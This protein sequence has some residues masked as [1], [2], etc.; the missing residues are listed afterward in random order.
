MKKIASIL[1]VIIMIFT[2][3][4][5]SLSRKQQG[6]DSNVNQNPQVVDQEYKNEIQEPETITL[7]PE[8]INDYLTFILNAKDIELYD[9][10]YDSSTNTGHGKLSVKIQPKKRGTFDGVVLNVTLVTD[11][12]GWVAPDSW[13]ERK[14]E[15]VVSLDGEFEAEYKINARLSSDWI[16]STPKF[17]LKI[18]SVTGTF[19]AN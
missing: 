17:E 6:S 18:N 7:T 4:G 8:N 16:S 13:E 11:T 1:T 14:K 15:I 9:W 2:L 10:E 12:Q 19:T 3:S 5:C